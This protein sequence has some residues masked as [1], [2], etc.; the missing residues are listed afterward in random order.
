ML[1]KQY[2]SNS[3]TWTATAT[4]EGISLTRAVGGYEEYREEWDS[5]EELEAS[6]AEV[7]PLSE[8]EEWSDR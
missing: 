5:A 6:M 2:V 1:A 8:W 4:D 3:A 7:A